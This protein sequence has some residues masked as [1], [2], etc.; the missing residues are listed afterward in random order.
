[1][2]EHYFRKMTETEKKN[3][4]SLIRLLKQAQGKTIY[5]SFKEELSDMI[6]RAERQLKED[7]V[8]DVRE[9]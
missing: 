1:M 5:A 6:E 4:K 8:Y 9:D 7:S 2:A 3:Q